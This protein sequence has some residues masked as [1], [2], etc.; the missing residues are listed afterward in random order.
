[1]FRVI[2][3][4][5]IEENSIMLFYDQIEYVILY[6]TDVILGIYNMNT[7]VVYS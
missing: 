3:I 7:I 5:S 1:M 4:S 2:I 6:N